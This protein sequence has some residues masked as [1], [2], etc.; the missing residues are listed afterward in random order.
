MRKALVV[1][2]MVLSS[3]CAS[4]PYSTREAS[5]GQVEIMSTDDTEEMIGGLVLLGASIGCLAW[6]LDAQS[7]SITKAMK[8]W[9]GHHYTEVMATWG[10]PSVV[11]R[12]GRGGLILVYLYERRWTT[13]GYQWTTVTGDVYSYGDWTSLYASARTYYVPPQTYGYTAWRM[14]FVNSQ[15]VVYKVSWQGL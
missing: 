13:Q 7:K 5:T 3:G 10:P 2:V 12:D 8:S 6:A 4:L 9:L 14:F 15:G 11:Y 1:G